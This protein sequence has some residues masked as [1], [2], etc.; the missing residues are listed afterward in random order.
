MSVVSGG[1]GAVRPAVVYGLRG[2]R[3][4]PT[5]RAAP[6]LHAA[7]GGRVSVSWRVVVVGAL[8]C[9]VRRAHVEETAVSERDDSLALSWSITG[10]TMPDWIARI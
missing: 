10:W 9:A 5:T 3:A 6:A 7:V 1:L 4:G 2:L 8:G